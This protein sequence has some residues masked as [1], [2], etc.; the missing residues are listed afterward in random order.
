MYEDIIATGQ[1]AFAVAH[2]RDDG[3]MA[4]T[5]VLFMLEDIK[6]VSQQTGDRV[7]F[8]CKHKVTKRV[9]LKKVLNPNVWHDAS[10]YLRVELEEL[11]DEP[12]PETAAMQGEIEQLVD[13]LQTV[14]ELQAS[15]K[16]DPRFRANVAA[17]YPPYS[18][19]MGPEG[20]ARLWAL[21]ALWQSLAVQR[22]NALTESGNE[23]IAAVVR[24]Y[25]T[26]NNVEAVAGEK[27]E[28]PASVWRD[29]SAIQTGIE[30]EVNY[31]MATTYK[32]YLQMLQAAGQA[33]R[34]QVMRRVVCEER[35]RLENK[36]K[37]RGLFASPVDA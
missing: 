30:K 18:L 2:M 9:R 16:E 34:L 7:K 35:K 8:V 33:E 6:E 1:R 29:I 31:Q 24:E 3:R 5:A 23:R 26:A 14:A 19:A 15:L 21:A 22:V 32:P 28:L 37:F 27:L 12:A 13:D 4:E 11:A 20:D 10:G 25:L 36:D 17:A